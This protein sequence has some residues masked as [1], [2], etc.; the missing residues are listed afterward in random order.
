M[1]RLI[2]LLLIGY[3]LYL[4]IKGAMRKNIKSRPGSS[5]AG[6]ITHRDPVCGVY[7]TEDDAVIGRHE[8]KKIYFCS[9]ECLEKYR[10]RLEIES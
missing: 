8:G 6:E 1:L 4:I 2:F 7:V 3:C 9:M 5:P 10:D